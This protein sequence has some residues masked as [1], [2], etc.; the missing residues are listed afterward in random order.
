MSLLYI[1]LARILNIHILQRLQAQLGSGAMSFFIRKGGGSNFVAGKKRKAAVEKKK[2]KK[3][4]PEDEEIDSDGSD[5]EVRDDAGYES[6]EDIET[7]E[8]KRLRL[9]KLYLGEVE[10]ELLERQGGEGDT[11]AGVEERL[12]EDVDAERGKLRKQFASRMTDLDGATIKSHGDRVH[13]LSLTCLVVSPDSRLVYSGSKDAGLLVWELGS[14]RKVHRVPG[15]RKGQESYHQGHCTAVMALAVSSDGELLASGDL[16]KNIHV[17]STAGDKLAKLHTFLGHRDA[18][19][20]LKFRR[21][22]HTL[23][24]ASWDRSVKI[25]SVDERAYVETLFGHQDKICGLDAGSR[26][27]CVTAGGRDGSARVWKIVEESQLV[28]NGPQT[29]IDAI[30]LLNEE[31]WVTGGEDGHLA[32]WGI[33]KKKPL[34]VVQHSHGLDPAN[35]Q[36]HWVSAL[37]TRYNTDTV[38]TGSRDGAVRVWMVGEGFRSLVQVGSVAVVGFVN[39]L[40]VSGCGGWLVMGVGQEHRLGRWWREAGAKNKLLMLPIPEPVVEVAQEEEE[41]GEF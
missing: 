18:V 31:H 10:K 8:E 22:T 35:S 14:G 23:Y 36:P 41:Q 5:I 16:G 37:A 38:V 2:A 25:W 30:S 15:G 4:R 12:R 20:A 32:V 7:A 6:E 13:K 26:E 9:A 34:C 27:R 1:R 21:G 33:H 19:S 11:A 40:A 39:S 3:A 28:F 24:S 17:W 29:S